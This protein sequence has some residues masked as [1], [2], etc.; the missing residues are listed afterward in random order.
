MHF[1]GNVKDDPEDRAYVEQLRARAGN[2][3]VEFH[4]GIDGSTLRQLYREAALYWYATGYGHDAVEHPDKQEHF[5]MS[6]VE[7]MSAGAVPMAYDDGGPRET[8]V[9]GESGCLWRDPDALL[10][11]TRVLISDVA[12]RSRLSASAVSRSAQF[13]REVFLRRMDDIIV[14]LQRALRAKAPAD[15]VE[16][17]AAPLPRA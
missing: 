5:G 1:V 11:Q 8:I 6:I 9:A 12:L 15:D 13:G 16:G 4:V 3:P 14:R 7:A 17:T 2:A 10:A